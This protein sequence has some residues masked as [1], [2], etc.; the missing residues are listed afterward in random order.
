MR[1]GVITDIHAAP[2]GSPPEQWQGDYSPAEGA[3]LTQRAVDRLAREAVDGLVVLG[4]S[5]NEG[6]AASLS[7]VLRALTDL[8][9]PSW[10]VAGNV[11]LA[12]SQTALD[13]ALIPFGGKFRLPSPDGESVFGVSLAGLRFQKT[14][15]G[16][17]ALAERP[18]LAAWGAKPMLLLSHY[19]VISRETEATGAG[20]K[21]SGDAEGMTGL[22]N[23]LAARSGATIVLHGHLHLKDAIARGTLLQLGFP[24]LIEAGHEIAVVDV[25]RHGDAMLVDVASFKIGADPRPTPTIGVPPTSW[26][27]MNGAWRSI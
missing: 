12:Q 5:A 17:V 15:S 16:A 20:W 4:D 23:D 25:E 6:D 11:D 8:R 24:A 27:F 10:I 14:E 7:I 21:Y 26:R 19:P 18:D 1:L 9:V 3:A 2:A 13:D 22:A